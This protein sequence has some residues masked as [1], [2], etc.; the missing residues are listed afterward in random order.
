MSGVLPVISSIG[1]LLSDEKADFAVIDMISH[2]HTSQFLTITFA[3]HSPSVNRFPCSSGK[4]LSRST[5]IRGTGPPPPLG[6]HPNGIDMSHPSY[7]ID[8]VQWH[9][10]PTQFPESFNNSASVNLAR[11]HLEKFIPSALTVD[12]TDPRSARRLY[13]EK[14]L[15]EIDNPANSRGTNLQ[16]GQKLEWTTAHGKSKAC[17]SKEAIETPIPNSPT[18]IPTPAVAPPPTTTPRKPTTTL[19]PAPASKNGL[20]FVHLNDGTL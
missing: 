8:G 19:P 3:N 17:P 13:D 10:P 15:M 1:V 14:D 7:A 2:T 6:D 11:P 9:E 5:M 18:R 20:K 16:H 12:T 4:K